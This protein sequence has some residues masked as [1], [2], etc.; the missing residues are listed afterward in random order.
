VRNLELKVA[1][2]D[3]AAVR[4]RALAAGAE[5]R[6]VLH[7]RDTFFASPRGRLKLRE[8]DGRAELIAYERPDEAGSRWSDYLLVPVPDP[9]LLRE[10]LAGTLGVAGEV[11]KRRELLVLERTRIHLDDVDGLGCYVELETVADGEPGIEAE[12][13]RIGAALGLDTAAAVPGAY[14]DLLA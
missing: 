6:G 8:E 13:E 5:D 3:L 9:A 14:V 2:R 1:V 12:H 4:A 7:Q 10:A 11:R